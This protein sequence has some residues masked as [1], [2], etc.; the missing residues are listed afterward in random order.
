MMFQYTYNLSDILSVINEKPSS[1][2]GL[3]WYLPRKSWLSNEPVCKGILV[4]LNS[5]RCSHLFHT[6]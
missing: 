5:V 1:S 3:L 6:F 2:M 4:I